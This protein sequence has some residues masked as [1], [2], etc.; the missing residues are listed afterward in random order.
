MA[1]TLDNTQ[2]MNNHSC[3]LLA[4][5]KYNKKLKIKVLQKK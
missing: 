1:I 2:Y 5:K 3:L 4:P